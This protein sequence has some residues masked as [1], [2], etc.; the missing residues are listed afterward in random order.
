MKATIF[1]AAILAPLAGR[2]VGEG[3]LSR[4]RCFLH[5]AG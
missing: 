5:G 4:L 2:E 1:L 3:R